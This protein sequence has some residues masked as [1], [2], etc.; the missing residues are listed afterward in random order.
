MLR[1][2]VS[3]AAILFAALMTAGRARAQLASGINAI[4]HDSVITYQEVDIFAA[5]AIKT[6]SQLLRS[7]REAFLKKVDELRAAS[8]E[9]LVQRQLILHDFKASG[10]N[11]PESIIEESVK[12]RIEERYSGDR[13]TL[14]QTLQAQGSNFEKFR[15]QMRDLIIVDA[16][17]AHNI[18]SEVIISPKKVEKYYQ[19]HAQEYQVEDQVKLRMIVLTKSEESDTNAVAQ[20]GEIL[21]KLKGGAD[22]A[23]MARM[24]SQ[25]S[26]RGEGGDWGWG[27]RSSLRPELAEVAF[28]LKPGEMSP[29]IETKENCFIMLVE[30]VKTAHTRPLSE[31]HGEIERDLQR[32]ER[33]RLGDQYIKKMKQKTF[34]RY[35]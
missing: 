33:A 13:K 11:L 9:E 19:E 5:P 1:I 24:K 20:A 18:S 22:F 27:T 6:A 30:E 14:A 17:R 21:D 4:V 7:D 25:G 2:S 35:F 8:L 32:A 29:V 12:E 34:V 16:L 10:Y 23:E 28:N 3:T 15:Q 26:Q 31:V